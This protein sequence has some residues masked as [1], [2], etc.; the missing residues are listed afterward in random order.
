MNICIIHG[1]RLSGTGSNIYVGNIARQL[2]ARGHDVSI[3]CQEPETEDIDFVNSTYLF[4][5]TNKN[6]RLKS[7]RKTKFK[8]TCSVFIPNLK[9][10]LLVYVLDRYEGFSSVDTF[11]DAPEADVEDYV[12]RNVEALKTLIKMKKPVII[13]ANHSIMQPYIAFEATKHESIPYIVTVHGSAL[14]FSVRKRKSLHRFAFTG[15]SNAEIII[16]VS[17]YNACE[18]NEY[19]ASAGDELGRPLEIIPVGIDLDK[20]EIYS[21]KNIREKQE[22]KT[23]LLERLGYKLSREGKG[24]GFKLKCEGRSFIDGVSHKKISNRT[25]KSYFESHYSS[26]DA[27]HTD[28]DV[29]ENISGVDFI[30]Q[31]IILFI[32]KYLWTKGIQALITALPLIF[33]KKPDT[34]VIVV[35]FGQSRA[36]LESLLFALDKGYGDVYRHLIDNHLDIDPGSKADTPEIC[37]MFL[38]GFG[39]KSRTDEYFEKARSLSIDKKVFFT[40]IM[41]HEELKY[42][43]PLADVFVAPS[44]FTEAF[45]TVAVE[46]L[47]CGVLPVITYDYGFRE[48]HDIIYGSLDQKDLDGLNKLLLDK[49]FIPHMAENII[50]ILDFSNRKIKSFRSKCRKISEENYSWQAIADRYEKLYKIYTKLRR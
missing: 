32:G 45:G 49:E 23:L 41:N 1:Y 27:M 24:A 37:S 30:N 3:M 31:S 11:Q 18:L 12:F 15:L 29:I 5:D 2:V 50:R 34:T 14:N 13:H 35:G 39:R 26:Y 33:S 22:T 43:I 21:F 42:L 7:S 28:T 47:S 25:F 4:D 19:F 6:V 38:D 17:K 16:P 10:K 8:G 48:V 36:I 46:A 9:G 44:I 20:F 40:G